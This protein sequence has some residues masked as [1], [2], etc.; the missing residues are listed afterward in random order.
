MYNWCFIVFCYI[1][2]LKDK[3]SGQWL[4]GNE[5]VISL[6]VLSGEAQAVGEGTTQGTE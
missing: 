3:V 2:G 5:S 4:S 1:I 6:D